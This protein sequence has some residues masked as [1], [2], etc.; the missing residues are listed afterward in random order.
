M[1]EAAPAATAKKKLPKGRHLSQIKRERQSIKRHARNVTLK[2]EV[3][4][5]I[6]KVK[7]AV[8][9][10]DK[11]L[12]SDLLRQTSRVIQKTASK[13]ALHAR[14]ASRKISRLASMV[15]GI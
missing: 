11:K 1:A 4:T 10:K 7:D 8:V 15:S 13:G 14:N 2:S 6:K 3:K 12:A 9:K 5:Y